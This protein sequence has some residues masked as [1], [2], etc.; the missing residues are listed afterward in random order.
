M[1]AIT[2]ACGSAAHRECFEL[3]AYRVCRKKA[4]EPSTA[5]QIQYPAQP[6][7]VMPLGRARQACTC[8]KTGAT[9]SASVQPVARAYGG[10]AD[11]LVEEGH[12]VLVVVHPCQGRMGA[13]ADAVVRIKRGPLR[14]KRGERERGEA[15]LRRGARLQKRPVSVSILSR[16][17][18]TSLRSAAIRM[19][20]ARPLV[21]LQKKN[22]YWQL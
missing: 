13:G 8:A 6:R 9:D 10:A 15:G 21:R 19:S 17:K 2:Q 12:I 1:C 3:H 18:G 4:P 11:G 16:S 20:E 5:P 14:T 7:A 22:S